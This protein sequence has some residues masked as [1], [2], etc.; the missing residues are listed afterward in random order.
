MSRLETQAK[1]EWKRWGNAW[2]KFTF[3]SGC[4]QYLYCRGPRK[5][6]LLCLDCFDQGKR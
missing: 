4:R 2:G 5:N 3:C 1:I 6:K